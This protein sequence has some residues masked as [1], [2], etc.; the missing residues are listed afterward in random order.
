[1]QETSWGTR[2]G[3]RRE[4]RVVLGQETGKEGV[5]RGMFRRGGLAAT[6]NGLASP[7]CSVA[8]WGRSAGAEAVSAMLNSR[9]KRQQL[10]PPVN[11]IT[12]SRGYQSGTFSRPQ[13]HTRS[14]LRVYNPRLDSELLQ[15]WTINLQDPPWL[16]PKHWGGQHLAGVRQESLART[17]TFRELTAQ[18]ERPST[19]RANKMGEGD[20]ISRTKRVSGRRNENQEAETGNWEKGPPSPRGRGGGRVG[21]D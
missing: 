18:Q 8:G 6:R 10:G 16:H 11:S 19:P 2:E 15:R 4:R 9:C 7:L 1:M 21:L 17:P 5:R 14:L 3:S 13:P 20:G 12:R